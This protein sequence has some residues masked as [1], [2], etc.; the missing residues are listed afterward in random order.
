MHNTDNENCSN[1]KGNSIVVASSTTIDT[2]PDTPTQHRSE[3]HISCANIN[4]Q[5]ILHT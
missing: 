4:F 5:C 3:I 2:E 1:S